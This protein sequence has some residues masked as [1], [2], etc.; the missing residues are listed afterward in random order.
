MKRF[1]FAGLLL[2]GLSAGAI[3]KGESRAAVI[4]ELGEPSGSMKAGDK[5]ILVYKTGTITLRNGA[6][7][8][9]DLSQKY[10]QEADR[11]A[12][13][14]VK[15]RAAK[16]AE[17]EKQKLLYPEDHVIQIACAYT[18]TEDWKTLPDSIRPA[19]GNY[20]YDV[21]IPQG[22]YE[23]DER[24][25]S[26]LFLESPALWDSVKERIRKEK[27]LIVILQDVTQEKEIGKTMNGN[28]LAAFDDATAR[29]RIAR[30]YRFIAGRVP[31]A[32]FATM[33]PVA[34]II[35][36]EPDFRGFDK[37]DFHPDF[38]LKNPNLRA[39]VL[40]GNQDRRN[41]DYQAQFVVSHIPKYHID[42]YQDNVAV[43][44]QPLADKALDW[45]KKEYRIP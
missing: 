30:D 36:Q 19:Q 43:L 17:L 13:E 1:L 18:K 12:A 2:A 4:A 10:A 9:A 5:E 29:F 6:L 32:I 8:E 40:L 14:A 21:Y 41:V 33:R 15:I 25:Y 37:T 45:M 28:F 11:L 24:Y 7:I 26:C 39:Y 34:G 35:L 42:I 3:E 20:R 31:S 22:Y 27:W 38:L 23:S 16:Q 44:P